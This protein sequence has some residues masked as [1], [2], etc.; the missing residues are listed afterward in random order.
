MK[1]PFF[2]LFIAL[3]GSFM[4]SCGGGSKESEETSS[5]EKVISFTP[6]TTNISGPL[7]KA[8]EVVNRT[9]KP[10]GDYSK[11]L[12]VEIELK[13]ASLLP[14]D[15][16]PMSVGTTDNSGDPNYPMIANFVIEYLDEDGDVVETEEASEGVDRLLRCTEGDKATL[17]FDVPR[18]YEDITSFRII[19][20]YYPNQI[21]GKT[22]NTDEADS[23][24]SKEKPTSSGV[25]DEEFEKAMEHTN[26][27]LETVSKA[28][29]AMKDLLQ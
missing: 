12:N 1:K 18:K 15:F 23:Q 7:G 13:D 24:S 14:T 16:N 20:D 10:K 25:S 4:I 17:S 27:A 22:N 3:F 8:F 2:Y 28:S 21:E 11:R 6:Q 29:K 19:S 9:Y 26:K 5:E